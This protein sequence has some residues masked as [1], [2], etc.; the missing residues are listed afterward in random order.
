MPYRQLNYSLGYFSLGDIFQLLVWYSPPTRLLAALT[1]YSE[2]AK[3]TY[4]TKSFIFLAK[5]PTFAGLLFEPQD[6]IF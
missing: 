2:A 5:A 1:C 3:V 4:V 6:V